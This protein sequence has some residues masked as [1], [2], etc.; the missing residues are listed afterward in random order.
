MKHHEKILKK[1]HAYPSPAMHKD[2]FQ[3]WA[4]V[5]ETCWAERCSVRYYYQEFYKTL[6]VIIAPDTVEMFN[7]EQREG[8]G[9][10]QRI[11]AFIDFISQR[12]W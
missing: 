12:R 9:P 5:C 10:F 1:C 8:F 4:T 7:Y 3:I 2:A 6:K 11:G